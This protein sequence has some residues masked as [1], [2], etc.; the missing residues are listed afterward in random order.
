MGALLAIPVLRYAFYPLYAKASQSGWSEAGS[1]EEFANLAVPALKTI[2]FK[3]R[4]GWRE[5]VSSQS[6]YVTK[7]ER[8][9]IEGSLRHLSSSWL[10]RFVATRAGGVRLPLPWGTICSGWNPHLRSPTP[11]HGC[12]AA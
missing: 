12:A 5:V 1:T 4:D 7:R 11:R 8:W 10:Q 3:Q 2:D 6:V 9:S